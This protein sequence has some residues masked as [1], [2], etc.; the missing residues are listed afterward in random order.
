MDRLLLTLG[1]L[2]FAGVVYAL[3]LKGWRGRQ[4]R[5]ADLPP[6]AVSTAAAA[7]LAGPVSGLFVGTTSADHWLDRIAVHHLSDRA[8][9]TMLVA[10][11][12]VH[13]ERPALPELFLP[14]GSIEAVDVETALGGKVVSTG[15]LLITWRLGGRL[16]RSAFRADDRADHAVL[17]DAITTTVE[18]T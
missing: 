14:W 7:A 4:R 9:A 13:V 12:G 17:L 8:A 11:D 6:T 5:Q 2:A 15:M 18:T 16:L 10:E 1:T 3:M